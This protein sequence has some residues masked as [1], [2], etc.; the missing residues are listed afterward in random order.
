MPNTPQDPVTCTCPICGNQFAVQASFL[1]QLVKCPGCYSAITASLHGKEADPKEARSRFVNQEPI[2]PQKKVDKRSIHVPFNDFLP[3]AELTTKI[4]KR[5]LE[6]DAEPI[7]TKTSVASLAQ[8]EPE[9]QPTAFEASR[10]RQRIIWPLWL[11]ISGTI[12]L[13]LGIYMFIIGSSMEKESSKTLNISDIFVDHE[14]TFSQDVNK[15][16][17]EEIH[18]REK[19]YSLT[20]SSR[21]QEDRDVEEV[22]AH[23]TAAMNELALYCMSKSEQ[24]KLN[25]VLNPSETASKIAHWAAYAQDKDFLPQ[26]AGRS[27]KDGDLLQISVL[28]DDNTIR[29]AIFMYDHASGKWK[30]DWEAWEGYS[31]ILPAEL[32][33]KKPSTP[34]AVRVTL[35]ASDVY[36]APFLQETSPES[37][38]N[39]AFSNFTLK[40][41]NGECINA[42][43]DRY[44]PL[45][46]NLL[47]L[48]YNGP[49]RLC[50]LIHYPSDVPNCQSV[51]IDELQ[52]SGWMS[53]STRKLLPPNN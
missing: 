15:D 8:E 43:V 26:E 45:A 16:L 34:V 40:F 17:M 49:V 6:E 27:S 22:A 46:L 5:Q 33:A 21:D 50:L 28:M 39:T 36:S 12:L 31:S 3:Q 20:H 47:K 42:Y 9:Y 30:L 11:W 1:G 14:A 4:R 19:Q 44:S 24:E 10:N 35:S 48:L 53:E 37:Y 51:I 7:I 32:I 29:P 38:H 2:S 13:A 41:P 52:H 18:K 25:Y 23:I